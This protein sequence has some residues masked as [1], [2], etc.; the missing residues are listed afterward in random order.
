MW[1]IL[2]VRKCKGCCLGG[3]CYISNTLHICTT[4]QQHCSTNLLYEQ[5]HSAEVLGKAVAQLGFRFSSVGRAYFGRDWSISYVNLSYSFPL[6]VWQYSQRVLL[7]SYSQPCMSTCCFKYAQITSLQ[8]EHSSPRS[9]CTT[10]LQRM[11]HWMCKLKQSN[12]GLKTQGN[13]NNTT[14]K[15]T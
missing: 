10:D 3:L 12:F 9:I 7:Q 4:P 1:A 8:T 11:S 5:G 13:Y 15:V 2:V 14:R 6:F